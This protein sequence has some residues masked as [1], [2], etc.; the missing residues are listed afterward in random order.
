MS[1]PKLTLVDLQ[2]GRELPCSQKIALPFRFAVALGNFDGVHT[3]H[4]VLLDAAREMARQLCEAGQPTHAA[5]WCFRVPSGAYLS[6]DSAICLTTP[7]EKLR[8][9]AASGLRYAFMADFPAMRMLSPDEF[10]RS[11]LRE[12]CRVDAVCCGFH[13]RFG[14]D[15][16]GSCEQL[17]REFGSHCRVIP[18]Q[19][20]H[21]DE[22][23]VLISSR[24]IRHLLR[25]G[26]CEA[27]TEMLGRPFSLT[28]PVIYGKQLGRTL[29]LPTANQSFPK[30][31]LVPRHGVYASAVLVDGQTY[32]GVSNI[33][34]RPTV[35]NTETINC[36]THLLDF[37]RDL[38]GRTIRVFLLHHLR[39]EQRFA[40]V[41]ALRAAIE[42]DIAAARIYFASSDPGNI[43][44]TSNL[45][46]PED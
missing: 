34:R 35:E 26:R 17:L 3:A 31:K 46:H 42:Q 14:K 18:A 33:G 12:L 6:D 2:N 10:L 21:L 37:D 23:D 15:G 7:Q 44:F 22:E 29:G 40:D 9:F 1:L 25:R 45:Y 30:E 41:F 5:A 28:A 36:E 39:D 13:F 43:V 32:L 11:V 8:E 20:M 19:Y 27:A 38:Y 4:R 16:S 24:M